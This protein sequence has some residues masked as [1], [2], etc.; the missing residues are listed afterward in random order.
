MVSDTKQR[1]LDAAERLFGDRGFPVTSLRDITAEAGVNL[2]SVN[3]H[4]GSKEALLAAVLERRV[5]PINARR[6]E[7]L[8]DA[9]QAAGG[10]PPD[11]EAIVRALV[12]PPFHKLPE[13]GEGGLSFLRLMGRIHSETNKTFRTTLLSQF[14]AVI[15]RFATAFQR[16]LP[17]LDPAHVRARMLF[18]VGAMAFTMCRCDARPGVGSFSDH[19][20]D[21]RLESLIQFGAAGMAATSHVRVPARVSAKG[22]AH[23]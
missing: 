9:D 14:E 13:W 17:H 8:E 20:P 11:V 23:R 21:E 2:A 5:Q 16:A 22:R 10:G 12:T 7:M 19:D 18:L 1:I 6:L 3:Y 15:K 4:F